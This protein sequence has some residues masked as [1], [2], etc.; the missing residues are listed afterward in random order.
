M[1]LEMLKELLN[2]YGLAV[3]KTENNHRNLGKTS[4]YL[5]CEIINRGVENVNKNS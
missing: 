3:I 1:T 2:Q 5:L 4:E